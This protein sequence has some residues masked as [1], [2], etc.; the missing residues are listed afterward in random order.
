MSIPKLT[1]R[2]ARKTLVAQGICCVEL[3]SA[4]DAYAL[5]AF[6]AGSHI[7][8]YLPGDIVRQ[9][10]LCNDPGET[11]RYVLGVLNDP[12]SRGGSKAMHEAVTEGCTLE[13]SEP[14]NHFELS[15][16]AEQHVL[17]AGGIGITPILSM[18]QFLARNGRPFKMHYC[19]RSKATTAF[20][21]R[22]SAP[23]LATHVTHYFDDAI[24]TPKLELEA[25][26]KT[27]RLGAHIYVC[28]PKGFMDW[29]LGTARSYGWPE[30]QLHYEFFAADAP[31]LSDAD[32]FDVR[33]A[34]S[35]Q[36]ITI[37]KDKTVVQAL[38]ECGI[39]IETSCEQGICGTC[40]TGVKEGRPDHKD[41]FLT[42]AEHDLNDQFTPCCSRSL[43]PLL[44]LDL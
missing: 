34:S 15:P 9:Y 10:S 23:S 37:A 40:L 14:K 13:I 4:S 1:V 2:V 11:D 35:G 17:F 26:L 25:E 7:D 44:V 21:Q 24:G 33:I 42:Q 43:S 22:L 16:D 32:S 28:G 39:E 41:L 18:V 5:P 29:V 20:A 27:L 38:A 36:V 12:N 8:V 6:T 3:V 30:S 19:T 31:D